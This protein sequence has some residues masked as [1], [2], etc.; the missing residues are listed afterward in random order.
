MSA[1]EDSFIV[2]L[3]GPRDDDAL[4]VARHLPVS[5]TLWI[6][7][8]WLL[9]SQGLSWRIDPDGNARLYV[10]ERIAHPVGCVFYRPEAR[11]DPGQRVAA[12][13]LVPDPALDADYHEF[14]RREAEA[15]LLGALSGETGRWVNSP[16]AEAAADLKLHQLR[17]AANLGLS[18]PSTVVTDDRE[19]LASFWDEHGGE[20]VTKAV[21][22]ASGWAIAEIIRTRRV[23]KADLDMLDDA[24]PCITLFQEL[25]PAAY[26]VRVTLAGDEAF[27]CAIHSQ[28]GESPIDWRLDQSVPMLPCDLPGDVIAQ[29]QH[30]KRQ[31]R[32]DFGAVDLRIKPDGT[33][34]FLE[35]N[36]RGAFAFVEARTGLPISKAV[37]SL[38]LSR[39]GS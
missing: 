1:K 38:L 32:L 34:V 15:T 6:D 5:R 39:A 10:G 25:I 3:A 31:L 17:L 22:S 4:T 20:V 7:N 19:I 12:Y 37:A 18:V 26:D 9:R 23:V 21:G 16:A 35:I 29:L 33:P 11:Y 28:E 2:L 14:G 13:V 36:A 24:A 27:A 8:E 30:L